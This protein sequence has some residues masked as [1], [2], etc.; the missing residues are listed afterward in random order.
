MLP[1]VTLDDTSIQEALAGVL[2]A[3]LA[4]FIL[5]SDFKSNYLSL[6]IFLV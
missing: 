2:S 6:M 1:A 4:I 5:I 3:I